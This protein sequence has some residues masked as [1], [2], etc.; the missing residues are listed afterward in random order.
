MSLLQTILGN[1]GGATVMEMAKKFGIGEDA[2]QSVLGKIVPAL[3]QGLKKNVST[4]SGLESLLGA[5]SKG[6]HQKYLENP[7]SLGEESSILEGN[8]ILGHLLGSKDVSRNVAGHVAKETGQDEGIIKKMLPMVANSLM[9]ALGQQSSGTGM[10]SSLFSNDGDSGSKLGLLTSF[11][12]ADNDGSVMDD[13][14]GMAK[15][16]FK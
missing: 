6:N 3:S 2:T 4:E 8:K 14:L 13:V 11:L 12:D 15:K 7:Q 9:G 10:L 1:Q 5:L 16:F